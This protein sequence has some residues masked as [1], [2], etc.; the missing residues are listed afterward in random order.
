METTNRRVLQVGAICLCTGIMI[1]FY[2]RL[3]P[4]TTH[5]LPDPVPEPEVADEHTD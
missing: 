3:P 4:V 2:L 1:G 5:T